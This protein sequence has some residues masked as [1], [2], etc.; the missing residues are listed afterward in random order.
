MAKKS[1]PLAAA[2]R[3]AASRPVGAG[4]KKRPKKV[5]RAKQ[6]SWEDRI[7]ALTESKPLAHKCS[8]PGV[9]Q[10]TRVRL[11]QAYDGIDAYTEGSI[12]H[13]ELA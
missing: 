4:A 8:S 13:V 3:A 7:L 2:A 6:G 10:V 5:K 1:D 12:L 9:A 11:M